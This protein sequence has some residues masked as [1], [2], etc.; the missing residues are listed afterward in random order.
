MA[1]VLHILVSLHKA[2]L[3]SASKLMVL[4]RNILQWLASLG[5]PAPPLLPRTLNMAS[6]STLRPP[7]WPR[8][9]PTS[10]LF[11]GP[12]NKAIIQLIFTLI[13]KIWYVDYATLLLLHSPSSGPSRIFSRLASL[14]NGVALARLHDRTFIRII[15]TLLLMSEQF[16]FLLLRF[17]FVFSVLYVFPMLKK[18]LLTKKNLFV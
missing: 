17:N 6:V 12:R 5:W 16:I 18:K 2:H 7:S 10:M 3:K 11:G 4:G 13:L 8:L 9:K 14:Y 15:M 1:S